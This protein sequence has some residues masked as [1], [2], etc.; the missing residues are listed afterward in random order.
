MKYCRKCYALAFDSQSK[1]AQCGA[2]LTADGP[3]RDPVPAKNGESHTAS[4]QDLRPSG[5]PQVLSQKRWG[6]I[7]WTMGSIALLAFVACLCWVATILPLARIASLSFE[8]DAD[9]PRTVRVN[10]MITSSGRLELHRTSRHRHAQETVRIARHEAGRQQVFRWTW[11]DADP[12]DDRIRLTSRQWAWL[13]QGQWRGSLKAPGD[14][15]IEGTVV[16]DR[17]GVPVQ[18][19][20]VGVRGTWVKATTDAEGRFRI[21]HAPTG[22]QTVAVSAVGFQPLEQSCT[23]ANEG[24]MSL[25]FTLSRWGQTGSPEPDVSRAN[26]YAPI[27]RHALNAPRSVEV[28]I[29]ALAA[30]LVQPASDDREKARAIY[31]WLTD[32]IA[33]DAKGFLEKRKGDESPEAVLRTRRA[34]C[35]GY[36]GLLKSLGEAVGLTVEV[37]PGHA[38]GFGYSVG[39]AFHGPPD[40]AWNV[41]QIN[42]YWRLLDA[43]W[44]AGHVDKGGNFVKHFEEHYFLTEPEEFIY[45]HYPDA[46][47]WQL[48]DRPVS[49]SEFERLPDLKPAFFQNGLAV[50]SHPSG[51]VHTQDRVVVTF[52]AAGNIPLAAAVTQDDRKLSES[53]S[54]VQKSGGQCVLSAVFPQPADY[55]LDLFAKPRGSAKEYSLACRYRIVTTRR[56]KG[57]MGFP[58]TY[59]GFAECS[60]YLHD[61]MEGHLQS[62]TTRTFR[63]AVPQAEDVAVVAN[64]HWSHL[65]R[66]GELFEGDVRIEKGN[67]RVCARF[68][69]ETQYHGLLAYV[70]Y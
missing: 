44:G 28:S 53:L 56:V 60:A 54:L 14:G 35:A 32:R 43:S 57:P 68:S 13:K 40:H 55:V 34:L 17:R 27:D 51:I 7:G 25:K 5:L 65:D 29:R 70:G 41:V 31:R 66:K 10:Y 33:Y 6:R 47:R 50:C 45:G 24:P 23:I 8:P 67:L 42:G 69:G 61:P 2:S 48:L 52:S 46:T 21:R 22:L 62:K 64:E 26:E 4:P 1:C 36:A 59:L 58:Q 3:N 37:V 9:D 16:S 39:T 12:T 15:T 11:D 49:L 18:G 19:V 30:Y 38:K 20:T 63:I